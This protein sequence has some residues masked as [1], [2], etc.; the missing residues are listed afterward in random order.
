MPHLLP[1]ASRPVH[2]HLPRPSKLINPSGST[3]PSGTDTLERQ[4]AKQ[5]EVDGEELVGRLSVPG[6]LL[7]ARALLIEPLRLPTAHVPEEGA[8]SPQ[9]LREL[10]SASWGWWALRTL[11]CHQRVVSRRSATLRG[12]Q[13]ALGAHITA[14][15]GEA[16]WAAVQVT[17]ALP[18]GR[19]DS[20]LPDLCLTTGIAGRGRAWR[21]GCRELQLDGSSPLRLLPDG[22]WRP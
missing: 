21:C 4:A 8:S 11:S 6:Y 13:R 20:L 9:V 12:Q 7:L 3:E 18:P 2:R 1:C 17:A 16:E 10:P 5:L 14:T 22:A 15:W 19:H